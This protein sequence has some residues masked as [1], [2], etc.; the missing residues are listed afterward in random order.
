MKI[1]KFNSYESAVSYILEIPRFL[2]K[3]DTEATRACLKQVGEGNIETVIHIAGTNGKG[4]TCAFINS[5]Y[6]ALGK[7]V[8]MFT[9]PHLV[10]IRERIQINGEM[11]SKEEFLASANAVVDS[12]NVIRKKSESY[13]PSFFEFIFLICVHYFKTSDV[14]V[15]IYETGLGGRLDATNSLT[16]KD[17]CVITEVGMDHMEYLGDTYEKIAG[18]KAGIIAA[19]MPVVFWNGRSE[20]T[21]VIE[22]QAGMLGAKAY[23]VSKENVK[24][25]CVNEKSI[26]FSYDY[27]Y[28]K[29][30]TFMVNSYAHYQIYNAAMALKTLQVLGIDIEQKEV[31]QGISNMNWPGRMEQVCE[32]VFIDGGHNVDGIEAFVQS[33][34]EDGCKGKRYLIYSAVSDKQ[35]DVISEMLVGSG[36]FD[37]IAVCEIDSYRA[38]GIDELM[39][40]FAK[41][42]ENSRNKSVLKSYRNIKEAMKGERPLLVENDRLY[43][44]GSLYL[45]GEVKTYIE[46]E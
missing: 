42:M 40:V 27:S 43:I 4:S 5:V 6:M 44:C 41:P 11:I 37:R 7:K 32:G 35:I 31:K 18:E 30:A 9:S 8:G 12:I 2:A 16:K 25:I 19:K 21:K 34:L 1:D 20:C 17:I 22:Q 38:T 36:A 24:I 29:N 13:H 28:D 39:S 23:A 45:V 10:D 15:A 3:N 46:A 14:D 33:V 26:D